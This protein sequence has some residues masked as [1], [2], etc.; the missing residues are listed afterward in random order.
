M[1]RADCVKPPLKNETREDI[2][3]PSESS[4]ACGGEW[5]DFLAPSCAGVT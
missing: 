3:L 2:S 1:L 4:T 5:D